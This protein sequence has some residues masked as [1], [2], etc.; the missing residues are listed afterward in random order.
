[1]AI[2]KLH[3]R[4]GGIIARPVVF[5]SSWTTSHVTLR[6]FLS[7]IARLLI[8]VLAASPAA[9]AG[10]SASAPNACHVI[11]V[12][13]EQTARGVP[14]VELETVDRVRYYTD[15]NGLV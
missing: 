15:S 7:L 2:C 8:L 3:N 13:D 11:E 1:M 14:L 4:P 12:V 10:A 6:Q 9:A 5:S